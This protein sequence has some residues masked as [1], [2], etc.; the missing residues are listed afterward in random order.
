M[1][2][3]CVYEL[4]KTKICLRKN[5]GNKTLLFA[6]NYFKIIEKY[7]N[8]EAMSNFILRGVYQ[9]DKNTFFKKIYSL[10]PGKY[11]KIENKKF[12]IQKWFELEVKKKN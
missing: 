3:F 4:G 5:Q 6:L 12:E 9:N 8:V 2:A 10:E 11:L 1:F 7:V